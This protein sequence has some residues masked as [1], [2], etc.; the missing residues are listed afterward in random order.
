MSVALAIIITAIIVGGGVYIWQH[1]KVAQLQQAVEESVTT[2]TADK[3]E[4]AEPLSYSTTGIN[5]SVS[6]KTAPFDYTTDQLK[7]RAEQCGSQHDVSYFDNLV[8]KFRGTNKIV[9]DFKYIGTNQGSDTWTVILLPN[10]AN[11]SSFDQFQKD[12]NVCDPNGYHPEM[13]NSNWLLFQNGCPLQSDDG[14]GRPH[15][16][17]EMYRI[18]APSFKLN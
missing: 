14:S 18:I 6:K 1:N 4:P 17:D 13:F 9:Y 12:F 16:C 7:F 5:V 3:E 15:G 2:K 10:K 11:Y 8:A